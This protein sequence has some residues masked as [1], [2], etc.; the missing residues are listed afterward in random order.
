VKK[1]GLLIYYLIVNENLQYFY[2]GLATH[3]LLILS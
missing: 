2:F 3:K 1:N